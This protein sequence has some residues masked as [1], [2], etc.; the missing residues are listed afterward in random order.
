MRRIGI[1]AAL[2]ACCAA[3]GGAQAAP[4]AASVSAEVVHR[5]LVE[6]ADDGH[7]LVKES[8][9]VL[10]LEVAGTM[11]LAGGGALRGIAAA[12]AGELAYRGQTQAGVPLATDA[13]HR[14]LE[15]ALQWRPLAPARWGEGW[16][17]LTALQQRR[18]IASQPAARGLRE[19]SLLLLPG[20][21]WTRTLEAAGWQWQPSVELRASAYHRF[22]VGFGGLFDD[23]ELRGGRR[24][25]LVLGLEA[26][27]PDSPWRFGLAWSHARQS[28]SPVQT[29]RRAGVPVG[30]VRQPRI[31][32]DDV[33]LRVTRSF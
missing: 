9:E 13:G 20:V 5:R 30:T 26:N 23:A 27:R 1:A 32:I 24:R 19:T 15:L 17:V 10:R 18:Q 6:R 3:A 29:L 8:G 11:A 16:L 12:A 7:R 31:A 2:A 33:A 25:E 14:D 4:E 28:A 21:R 22:D